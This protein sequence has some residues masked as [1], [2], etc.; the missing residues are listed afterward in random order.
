MSMQKETLNIEGMSC[1]HCVSSVN[2]ALAET[3]GV[4]V[5]NVEVGKA[6][7]AFDDTQVTRDK[8][9]EAIEDIGFTVV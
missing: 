8:L 9:V 4:E 5:E 6:Q 2:K 3:A 7:V 1:N